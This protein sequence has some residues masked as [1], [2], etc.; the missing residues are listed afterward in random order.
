MSAELTIDL[1]VVGPTGADQQHV[2]IAY[3]A[4]EYLAVWDDCRDSS[5]ADIWATRLASDGTILD[6]VGILIASDPGIQQKPA[7]AY[8][9]SGFVVAWEDLKTPGGTEAD[10]VAARVD[11]TGGVARLGTVAGTAADERTPVVAGHGDGSALVVWNAAGTVSAA[12]LGSGIG[13][14]VA[15]ASGALVER[16]SVAANPAGDYLVGWTSS[17]Q[18][19]G[20]LVTPVG[21]L[22]GGVLTISAATGAQAQSSATFDGTNYDVVW[23]S[24]ASG[25]IFGTRVSS[26]GA[27]LDTHLQGTLQVGGVAISAKPAQ[28]SLPTIACSTGACLVIWQDAR[29]VP[30]TSYDLYGQLLTTAFARQGSELAI[31]AVAGPQQQPAVATG[32]G[33]FFAGWTD[34]RDNAASQI[35]GETITSSGVIGADAVIGTGNN[36]ESNATIGF[37]AGVEGVFWRDSR[38]YP[39]NLY[40]T[41][42]DGAGTELDVSAHSVST[43]SGAQNNPSASVE[44]GGHTLVV[45]SD[46]RNAS[47]DIYGARVDLA[48]G[49]T[50]DASGIAIATAAGDQLVP[51]IATNGT[52][53]LAVWQDGRNGAFD[54]Y[55]A[56]IDGSGAVLVPDIAIS[57]ATGAQDVPAVTWDPA[58][59]Q[60]VVAWQD[61]RSGTF[62]IYG[63]RVAADGTVLDPGGVLLASGSTAPQATPALASSASGTLVA[64]QDQRT[65]PTGTNIYATRLAAG[66]SLSVLDPA[67][68]AVS[69]SASKQSAPCVSVLGAAYLV[70]WSDDRAGN[71]DLYG[72]AVS[73]GGTL[74]AGEIAIATTSDDENFAAVLAT[75]GAVRIA[76]EVH[77]LNTRRIAT[78]LISNALEAI[79]VTPVNPSIAKGLTQAFVATGTYADGSSASLTSSVTWAS[80]LPSVATMSS[81]VATGAGTGTTTISATLGTVSGSTT[82]M[83]TAPLLV[84]LSV[85]PANPSIAKGTT[86][87]FTVLGTYTDGSTANLTSS[88]TWASSL[89]SVATMS[90]NVATGAGIGTTTISATLG[91]LGASTTLTVTAPTLV[92]ISVAPAN[93]SIAKGTTQTFTATGTYTDASTADVTASATWSSS[94]TS[95]AMLAGTTATGVGVGTSTIT[96]AVGSVSGSTTLTVTAPT[97]SDVV[98]EPVDP[99]IAKGTTQPFTLTAVYSDAT[100]ADVTALATWSSSAP[101]VATITSA[102]LATGIAVGNSTITASYGGLSDTSVLTVSAAK[103]SSIAL[104]PLTPTIAKSTTKQFTATGTFTDGTTQDLTSQVTWASAT[105]TVATITTAGLATG[106]GAGTSTI[107]ATFSGKTGSTTLTVT[108]A[109]LSSITVTPATASVPK[110]FSRQYTATG[111]FSDGTTQ[112]LTSLVTWASSTTT[113][114]TI[115]SA[116]LA[117]LVGVGTTTITASYSG[118]S[119]TATLTGTAATLVTIKVTPATASISKGVS[120][121]LKATGTYSD[122][123]TLDITSQVSWTSSS[124][125]IATVNGAGGKVTGHK[126]GT[127]TITASKSGISGTATIT[128]N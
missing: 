122:G 41:R 77:R 116:G 43:G 93:P 120:V 37:A 79:V 8:D 16:P 114:A 62:Q 94:A 45:W 60:F 27:A 82:L 57:T 95:I 78:R 113:V 117:N 73:A 87:A 32:N 68:I 26:T 121:Q 74:V 17:N 51:A 12:V 64:W 86:Q 33:T 30:T 53:A 88:V 21:A 110:G 3:G 76:Y 15:I 99:T 85:A 105:T 124:K 119:G 55:G 115:T 125:K 54:V 42:L 70:A 97:L 59:S 14:P 7:V 106:V 19:R 24:A 80:S 126:K 91:V 28:S 81:S 9:G 49:A 56:L 47:K 31:R 25:Y 46:T 127:A 111:N 67:G 58:S 128:V 108:P 118:K 66:A 5:N 50:L 36:R 89:P 39:P 109:T 104:T 63:A 90:G 100:T 123:T 29:N 84:S 11:S 10:I 69:T 4:G 1:P 18:L 83:V 44:L 112:D 61:L 2:A 92:S 98:L 13:A 107:S 40:Y 35:F 34:L 52:V 6:P 75:S 38:G 101:A 20:Q 22:D 103:L 72:Q 48:T 71:Q 23:R 65:L 96:A 102:G